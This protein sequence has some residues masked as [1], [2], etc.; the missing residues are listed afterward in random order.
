MEVIIRIVLFFV[1]FVSVV[2]A[3]EVTLEDRKCMDASPELI[4]RG[5]ILFAYS[6]ERYPER[7]EALFVFD[8]RDF[9]PSEGRHFKSMKEIYSVNEG[10]RYSISFGAYFSELGTDRCI[11]FGKLEGAKPKE[12]ELYSFPRATLNTAIDSQTSAL[13]YSI[14]KTCVNQGDPLPGQEPPCTKPILKATSDLNGNGRK[15]FWYSE[16]YT[17]DTGFVVAELDDSGKVLKK[18]IDKCLD[19]D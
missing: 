3:Q 16:P 18:I 14:N 6:S 13:F 12:L 1:L 2:H 9:K 11:W 10:K 5:D 7:L 8:G 19:C 4:G 15:E 17:W